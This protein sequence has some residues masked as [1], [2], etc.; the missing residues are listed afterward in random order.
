MFRLNSADVI[1]AAVDFS[2]GSSGS[3]NNC[4][5][6]AAGATKSTGTADSRPARNFVYDFNTLKWL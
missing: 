3:G 4:R 1:H 6:A 2:I 5:T